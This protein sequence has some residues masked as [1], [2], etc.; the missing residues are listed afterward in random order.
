MKILRIRFA[1]LN[2][3]AGEWT[4]DLTH[5]AFRA[6]GIFAITGHTG[7]GKS[8]ILD[9]I[10]LALYGRTPRLD[11]VTKSSNEI[12]SRQTGECFAEVVFEAGQKRYRSH[13][14]Q[15]RSRRKP[16]GA[17]QQPQQEIADD[18]TGELLDTKL[19]GVAGQ[20]VEVTG[21]DFE[22]FTRSMLLAQGGFAAFLQAA[23]DQRAPIL[24]QI[25]GTAVYSDI[26]MAVHERCGRE[27][28]ALQQLHLQLSGIPVLSEQA[29]KELRDAVLVQ[30][31]LEAGLRQ[32][33]DTLHQ[34][35]AWL[36]RLAE[37][38]AERVRLAEQRA[39]HGMLEE[40]F[41]PRREALQ[42]ATAAQAIEA[43]V[44][45]TL[46]LRTA[47]ADET[48]ALE[49]CRASLPKRQEALEDALR[50]CRE[51]EL[52][53]SGMR[54]AQ[55]R[56]TETIRRVRALDQSSLETRE[57]VAAVDQDSTQLQRA[58]KTCLDR[59][60]QL[61]YS[62]DRLSRQLTTIERY[63]AENTRDAG[64]VA[65]F[66]AIQRAFDSLRERDGR[67][68][69]ATHEHGIA[70]RTHDQCDVAQRQ[71][72]H[73][74]TKNAA[75]LGKQEAAVQAVVEEITRTLQQR[76]P[77]G[78]R[79]DME[80]WQERRRLL[81]RARQSLEE[82]ATAG[83]AASQHQKQL[84]QLQRELQDVDRDTRSLAEQQQRCVCDVATLEKQMELVLRIRNLEAERALLVEGKEC[85]LC[86]ATQHPYAKEG[87]PPEMCSTEE[88]LAKARAEQQRVSEDLA[89]LRVRH[90]ELSSLA[91]QTLAAGQNAAEAAARHGTTA[92]ELLQALKIREQPRHQLPRVVA[93][94]AAAG[95]EIT[96][97]ADTLARA[98]EL[99][100]KRAAAQ[101]PLDE[102]RVQY[103][104]SEKAL[105]V[106][107]HELGL[108][109]AALKRQTQ[110]RDELE[111]QLRTALVDTAAMIRPYGVSSVSMASLDQVLARLAQQRTQWEA[112]QEQKRA[113][114]AQAAELRK[115]S[116]VQRAHVERLDASMKNLR[117]RREQLERSI[118]GLQEQRKTLFGTRD[119][120]KEEAAT[121]QMVTTQGKEV[122]ERRNTAGRREHE[123]GTLQEQVRSLTESTT[124]RAGTLST[125]E[126][127]A[128]EL[129]RQA[130]FADE[131]AFQAA[132]LGREKLEALAAE[133]RKMD[134]EA[135]RLEAL[136]ARNAE[137]IEQE[138][139]RALTEQTA[140]ELETELQGCEQDLGRVREELGRVKHQ[141][142]QDEQYRAESAGLA[143]R[144]E[145][146]EAEHT[147]WSGLDALIGSAD[148]KKFRN[149]AQGITFEQLIGHANARL[150]NMTDRYLLVRDTA[151]P[152]ELSVIDNYQAGVVRSTKNLSGGE[153]FL[154]SLSLALGLSRMSSRNVPVDSL[155]LDEGFGT[156]DEEALETALDTLANLHEEGKLIGVISH[157]PALKE[158]IGARIQVSRV[159]GGRS[160]VSG[161]GCRREDGGAEPVEPAAPA[162]R[163]GELTEALKYARPDFFTT[164]RSAAPSRA[165][166]PA[167]PT[168]SSTAP[169]QD[170]D[171][172]S[173]DAVE[174]QGPGSEGGAAIAEEQT[175]QDW[176]EGEA[177]DATS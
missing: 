81:E 75:G 60:D 91:E 12:M 176:S 154:V 71:A 72:E 140:E 21:M 15:H 86:G 157:V 134:E 17:L 114:D 52:K 62:L 28:T 108:A 104:M 138:R 169:P 42:H 97:H 32:R 128:A 7:A 77:M 117:E 130:G 124:R 151:A 36:A 164:V 141:L 129:L 68:R 118:G 25:T 125:A 63:L 170:S 80:Q 40:R 47:Q 163:G 57:Q 66:A 156:L 64:L 59:I 167:P 94:H 113:N 149:F 174:L 135:G 4:I 73:A 41:G 33:E 160:V 53:L 153:S 95:A 110:L 100:A 107:T 20:I 93:E 56:E 58:R 35:R 70:A 50:E 3:L 123:L 162:L 30:Q 109:E 99:E 46:A 27:R 177:G 121:E 112:M 102:A 106:A 61:Q 10:C 148:G 85:P 69:K 45:R 82:Q 92:Q 83:E 161:P 122:E 74:H 1:N 24:E 172:R 5:A 79:D 43:D 54:E 131:A 145:A 2:S 98:A 6:D 13:W 136:R 175:V 8:T 90:V 76:T 84:E 87:P 155:F 132:R 111:E 105:Q 78:W 18:A 146:Q 171:T 159:R 115:D 133:A 173:L 39:N 31:S 23:A 144:I 103:G 137:D 34:H 126:T 9:A 51:A 29:E 96:R 26:S 143:A 168:P 38:E 120:A 88:D 55:H 127:A 166:A 116:D 48:A 101:K 37:L 16:D 165:P 147:K 22:R 150:R 139:E 89:A 65:E 142:K 44:E 19:R 158:R 14:S 11:R 49:T 67:L 152:L 119:P